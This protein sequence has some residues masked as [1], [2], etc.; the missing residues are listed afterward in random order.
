MTRKE[1]AKYIDQSLLNAAATQAEVDILCDEAVEHG[2]PIVTVNPGWIS[3]CAARL[4]G[5][6]EAAVH[7]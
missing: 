4:R 3:Y 5:G 6:G 2:F 1:L 7:C